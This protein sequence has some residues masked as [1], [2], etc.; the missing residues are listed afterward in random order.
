MGKV[1]LLGSG[2]SSKK[3]RIGKKVGNVVAIMLV[4]SILMTTSL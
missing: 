1:Q 4:V 3:K 2:T